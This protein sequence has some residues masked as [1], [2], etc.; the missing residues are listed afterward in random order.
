MGLLVP[1]RLGVVDAPDYWPWPSAADPS[2]NRCYV[3]SALSTHGLEGPLS[4]TVC[5]SP[6]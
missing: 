4:G 3:V 5:G 2:A 6:S 1:G